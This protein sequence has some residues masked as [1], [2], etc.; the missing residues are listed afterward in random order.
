[1]RDYEGSVKSLR[2]NAEWADG[3][4]WE[5]PIMLPDNLR[6]AADAMLPDDFCSYGERKGGDE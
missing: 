3:N 6:Q 5:V 4:V 1:M 2:E